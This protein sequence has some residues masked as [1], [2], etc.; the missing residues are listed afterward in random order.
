VHKERPFFP[1]LVKFMGSGP[2]VA[3]AIEGKD[4]IEV[5]RKLMGKTNLASSRAGHDPRRSR[6]EHSRTTSCNGSDSPEAAKKESS[7]ISSPTRA[8]SSSGRR[9]SGLDLQR[10]GR[11]QV[12]RAVAVAA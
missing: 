2:V 9:P 8:R 1:N 3:I 12:N 7:R 4:A 10:R 11:A 6:H 5:V